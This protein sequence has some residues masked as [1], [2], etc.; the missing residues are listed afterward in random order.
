MKNVLITGAAGFIGFHLAQALHLRGDNVLGYDNFNDYYDPQLKRDRQNIL[1]KL[2]IHITDGD[3]CEIDLLKKVVKDNSVTHIC[4]LAAQAGVRYSL[5]NPQAYVKSNLEGFVNVLEVCKDNPQLK[6]IYA[7]SS[8]VY[9]MNQKIP[10]SVTD[11]CDHQV[12]LYGASKKANELM[13][14]TYHHLYKIPCT[15]LRFFTVYG[16]FGRPDMAYYSFTQKILEGKPIQ[17]FNNGKMER[18]FTYVSDIVQGTM[19]AI[20]LGADWEIFNLG[21]HRPEKLDKF[22]SI[23]ENE[24]GVKA[25]KEY[26]P[27]QKGDVLATYADIDHSREKLGYEPK[28]SLE[29]G[30]KKFVAWYKSCNLAELI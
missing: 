17:L 16:P 27:M 14:S 20:D 8:S 25:I 19:A 3:I 7:S 15:G 21:N 18:D 24:L 9:G 11:R 12:S 13:A 29:E 6:L 4:H 23:L 10:F 1:K 28:V 22:I 2:G 30:L 26:L 5:E